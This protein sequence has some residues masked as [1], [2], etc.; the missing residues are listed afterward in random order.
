[1]NNAIIGRFNRLAHL[2]QGD[3]EPNQ[4]PHTSARAPEI[5]PQIFP[6]VMAYT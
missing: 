4:K 1:M 5:Y 3:T 2:L 6:G